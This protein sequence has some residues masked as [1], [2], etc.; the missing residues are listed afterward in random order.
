MAKGVT[1]LQIVHPN[2]DFTLPPGTE[3]G[4]ALNALTDFISGILIGAKGGAGLVVSLGQGGAQA[5]G[6]VTFASA[7]GTTSVTVNG[8]AFSQTTGTDAVRAAAAAAAITASADPLIA[9]VVTATSNLGVLT[10]RAVAYGA[11]GNSVTLATTGTGVT[12]SGARL[13][14]GTSTGLV[15]LKR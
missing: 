10:V 15:P 6:T 13:T 8:V 9:G 1:T 12:N 5:S 11:A 14:G 3:R 4:R 7:T 2:E